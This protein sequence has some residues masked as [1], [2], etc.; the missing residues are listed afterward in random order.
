MSLGQHTLPLAAQSDTDIFKAH[1][2]STNN[3]FCVVVSALENFVR[4]SVNWL[5]IAALLTVICHFWWRSQQLLIV[6]LAWAPMT[7]VRLSLHCLC[8][9]RDSHCYRPFFSLFVRAKRN[10]ANIVPN[11]LAHTQNAAYRQCANRSDCWHLL[12]HLSMGGRD[13]NAQTNWSMW[14][15]ANRKR[16]N[17]WLRHIP[18][19]TLATQKITSIRM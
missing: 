18:L 3:R 13:S 6:H 11:T 8:C 9:A 15:G 10:G 19:S 12:V 16:W 17:Y 2:Q 7:S 4:K 5:K 14:S 1:K